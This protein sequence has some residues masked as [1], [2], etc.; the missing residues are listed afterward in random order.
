MTRWVIEES[1]FRQKRYCRISTKERWLEYCKSCC[2]RTKE[3]RR[4]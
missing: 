2:R 3:S 4:S 1:V